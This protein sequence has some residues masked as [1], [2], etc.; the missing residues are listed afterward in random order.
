MIRFEETTKIFK[1][2]TR[3]ALDALTATIQ[4]GKITGVVG[5]DG[6][7]KTTALR[8]IA[9]LL[10]PTSGRIEV[11]G[12]DATRDTRTIRSFLGY[13]PQ[14]FGLYEDL[15]VLEN[16]TLYA[17][18]RNLPRSQRR[19]QFDKLLGFTGL[20]RFQNR[21]TRRL[22]GGMKQKLGL[23]CAFVTTPR[24][25]IL[26]EP[27]VGVDPLSR[28]ELWRMARELSGPETIVLWST[29]YM[30]EAGLCDETL[31]L[32]EG[33][34]LFAGKP[35]D[36]SA[37][38]RNRVFR[39][40]GYSALERR[41]VVTNLSKNAEV[42]D[43]TIQGDAIRVSFRSAL[44]PEEVSN[45][46]FNG[47]EATSTDPCFE[48]GFIDILRSSASLRAEPHSHAVGAGSSSSASRVVVGGRFDRDEVV[49]EA[50]KLTKR[51]GAF[52]AASEIEFSIKRGEIFGLLGPNG[53]GKSTSFKMLCGL[54]KPTSG[55]GFVSGASLRRSSSEARKRL[56]YMAQKFSL[57]P[58]LTAE[59]NLEFYGGVYSLDFRERRRKIELAL[60]EYDLRRYSGVASGSLPLGYK[61]RL[62]LAT[63]T[64]HSPVALFLDEP[65]SGVDPLARRE[66]WRR[67][68]QFASEGVAVLVTTH[69]MD[70]AEYCD[71]IALI[72]G[73]KKIAQGTP[74]ALK[75]RA[76]SRE[77]PN[78]TLEDAFIQLIQKGRETDDAIA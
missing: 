67:V 1:G 47:R 18:L 43:A 22:S 29:S 8:M 34:L 71:Q 13:M 61:Q 28:R 25:L 15:S 42:V 57:Y 31:L 54:L 20:E 37:R 60:D 26:D 65:T 66:F 38:V 32:N 78:P 14:K 2:A 73:G 9:G 46:F 72:L 5:P 51:F 12:Y 52:T 41:R 76:R 69:F 75:E 17:K 4:P 55:D 21:L 44:S 70:E 3:P 30:D 6:A 23:A 59:Q 11:F 64:L 58:N 39:I 53:A 16:L 62:A 48:D 19:S 33:R 27:G 36:L 45:R 77:L 49:V 68:D 40:R 74:E 10:K 7:G 50:R 63:A 56:G 24:L 35:Q